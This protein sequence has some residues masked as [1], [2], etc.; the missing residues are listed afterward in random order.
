MVA[1]MFLFVVPNLLLLIIS[2]VSYG[3]LWG[4]VI[5]LIA[6][7]ISSS[8]AYMIG[9]SI[10]PVIL[11]RLLKDK[12]RVKLTQLVRDYGVG[13]IILFRLS[14]VLSN[15]AISF[16]PAF[17]KMRYKRFILATL[18]GSAPIIGILAFSVGGDNF[19]PVLIW[20]SILSIAVYLLYLYI[21]IRRKRRRKSMA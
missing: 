3:P 20:L 17:L 10:G 12:V 14:P 5:S 9:Y 6:V 16:I 4:S 19:K 15:E 1:S 21:D 13:A 7:F 8:I 2:S 18:A 11:R